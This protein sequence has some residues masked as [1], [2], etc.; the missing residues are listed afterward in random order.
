MN[1]KTL[2]I[3]S[4]TTEKIIK[5]TFNITNDYSGDIRALSFV[6]ATDASNPSSYLV[7]IPVIDSGTYQQTITV[8]INENDSQF[9]NAVQTMLSTAPSSDTGVG[10]LFNNY[11][12]LFSCSY[13]FSNESQ[14][15]RGGLD[16]IT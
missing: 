5:F 8:E 7:S 15:Q 1:N 12:T 14:E 6:I 16:S 4:S 13:R 10:L 2:F 9:K 11:H 3:N